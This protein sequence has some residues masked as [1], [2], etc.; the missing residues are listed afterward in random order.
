VCGEIHGIEF[1]DFDAPRLWLEIGGTR[2][3][4]RLP[5]YYADTA[6][7]LA[8]LLAAEQRLGGARRLRIN[9]CNAIRDGRELSF[10]AAPG[11][12]FDELPLL[13]LEPHWLV[14]V[15]AL[16]HFDYCPR[17]YF[18][19]RYTVG[20][21]SPEMLRGT[22][23]HE[24]FDRILEAPAAPARMLAECGA[25][26]DDHLFELALAD[27]APSALLAQCAHHLNGLVFAARRQTLARPAD[28]ARVCP[29]RYLVNPR[30]GLKGK[31]DI[32]LEKRDGRKQ[33]LELKTSKPWGAAVQPGHALQV[34]AYQLLLLGRGEAALDSPLVVY[35]GEAARELAA[36]RRLEEH[37]WR[38]MFRPAPFDAA[39]AVR[40]MTHRNRLVAADYRLALEFNASI[41]KCAGCRKNRKQEALC[42]RL[43]ELGLR[44]G[45]AA[46][47]LPPDPAPVPPA[48]DIPLDAP[49]RAWFDDLNRALAAEYAAIKDE[50]GRF[51]AADPETRQQTG[52]CVAVA[53][54]GAPDAA[55]R[56]TL[57]CP[58][59]NRSELR[60][61]DPCLL[62]DER[63]PA[64]GECLEVYVAEATWEGLTVCLPP[65]V[66][67]LWFA[68]RWLDAN[69]SETH[70]ERNFAALHTLLDERQPHAR[71]LELLRALLIRGAQTIPPNHPPPAPPPPG[72]PGPELRPAQALAVRCACGLEQLLLIQGPPGSGKTYTLARI[73]EALHG[74]GRTVLAATF[75]HR[76]ADELMRKLRDHAPTVPFAKLGRGAATADALRAH[77]L[78]ER[79]R[80]AAGPPPAAANRAEL[81]AAMD[82]RYAAARAAIRAH[83][84]VLG[85]ASAW[86]SGRYDQLAAA[87]SG[88]ALF[89]VA[90]VDE[91]SQSLLTHT[92]GV[93][94]LAR[95]WIL[96]GDHQQL[97]PVIQSAGAAALRTTLLE[98]LFTQVPPQPTTHVT[99]DVQHRMPRALA[100]FISD[101]FY[102]GALTTGGPDRALRFPGGPPA[103]PVFSND[104]KIALVNVP[105]I[106][107]TGAAAAHTAPAEAA[108]I[109][110]LVAA[111]HAAGLALRDPGGAARLGVIAP[112]RAQVA[113]LR[114]ELERRL[115]D[116]ALARQMVDT[117]DRFQGDERDLIILS[118]CLATDDEAPPIYAD[119]RRLNVALSRAR[120][121]L[122]VVGDLARMRRVAVFRDL[123]AYARRHPEAGVVDAEPQ[124][125][126]RAK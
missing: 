9:L 22:I 85:T 33:A 65:G 106:G 90:V 81:A 60:E 72:G 88:R 37:F 59:G 66:H 27:L 86:M 115:G 75:T 56:L 26:L 57:A 78:E 49:A 7:D 50:Q 93:L 31:I 16:T 82:A 100:D 120:A 68:P 39:A 30:L 98:K 11:A 64:A 8:E 53:A 122:V 14:N 77:V 17:N 3:P 126:V 4:L 97:P 25:A 99:L 74:A 47:A 69:G 19:D 112:Y 83:P 28:I 95:R 71:N 117:V 84:V 18:M 15:T 107:K 125:A 51:L 123:I 12:R 76:A 38:F 119:P 6:R 96:V 10:P 32:V 87:I 104:W 111:A 1:G 62:S 102:G 108:R 80:A 45:A 34:L 124:S 58:G 118:A 20:G 21:T 29:E 113:W 63:G 43:H 89:D 101:A 52:R 23:V 94:R 110:E 5:P 92:L 91:A 48:A 114:R 13:A 35:S 2:W 79:I 67:D 70:F 46:P 121:K 36:G 103:D 41:R 24:V 73:I 61:G 44:G 54:A 40:I 42:F 55:G 116:P 105:M 109:G